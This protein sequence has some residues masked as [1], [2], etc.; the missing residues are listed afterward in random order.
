[1]LSRLPLRSLLVP[2]ALVARYGHRVRNPLALIVSAALFAFICAPLHAAVLPTGS[3]PVSRGGDPEI[4]AGAVTLN[5]QRVEVTVTGRAGAALC[6]RRLGRGS[7]SCT[8]LRGD[9][10]TRVLRGLPSGTHQLRVILNGRQQGLVFRATVQRA[11]ARGPRP[12]VRPGSFGGISI[13][14]TSAQVRA[15]W[16]APAAGVKT[17]G[18]FWWTYHVPNGVVAI[19]FD[20]SGDKVSII[21]SDSDYFL[22]PSGLWAGMD[23]NIGARRALA[24]GYT[25]LGVAPNPADDSIRSCQAFTGP[26]GPSGRLELVTDDGISEI[27]T[28]R[29]I[30][31]GEP[32]LLSPVPG[33]EPPET[34]EPT[35]GAV[36]GFE[37]GFGIPGDAAGTDLSGYSLFG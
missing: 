3:C 30:G 24:A 25:F 8:A 21:E 31:P 22:A 32:A 33:A 29:L 20:R 23:R 17:R 35:P 36:T 26:L 18:R 37:C 9:A 6:L 1:M 7:W 11:G 4:C 12:A 19:G 2:T 28:L 13:G 15:R 14:A 34:A 16:G 10:T 5:D 27:V